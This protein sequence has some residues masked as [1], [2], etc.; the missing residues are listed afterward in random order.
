MAMTVWRPFNLTT[1]RRLR[2]R[3]GRYELASQNK[4]VVY[5]GGTDDERNGVRGRLITHLLNN[6]FPTAKFFRCEYTTFFDESGIEMEG[7]ASQHFQK[8]YGRKSKYTK[9][10]PRV[11]DYLF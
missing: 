6:K 10:S 11:N 5:H 8:R 3:C 1:V 2:I 7:R 9:R 4:T